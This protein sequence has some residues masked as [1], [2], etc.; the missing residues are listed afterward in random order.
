MMRRI[1]NKKGQIGQAITTIPVLIIVLIIVILFVLTAMALTKFS[2]ERDTNQIADSPDFVEEQIPIGVF[3]NDYLVING[4]KTQIGDVFEI[5]AGLKIS[6]DRAKELSALIERKFELEYD[7]K[8]ESGPGKRNELFLVRYDTAGF[9]GRG[10]ARAFFYIDYPERR[11]ATS[12]FPVKEV[13]IG[14]EQSIYDNSV[15]PQNEEGRDEGYFTK[16]VI[17]AGQEI[18]GKKIDYGGFRLTIK[19]NIDYKKCSSD[20]FYQGVDEG[21]I[22]EVSEIIEGVGERFEEGMGEGEGGNGGIVGEETGEEGV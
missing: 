21:V 15:Y 20:D 8:D 16:E 1:K 9:F 11:V 19:E 17:K 5:I 22:G 2:I 6:D 12:K 14:D 18:N 7:C 10:E 4:K 13:P 3:L